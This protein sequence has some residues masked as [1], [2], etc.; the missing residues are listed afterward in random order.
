[1]SYAL[2]RYT[3]NGSNTDFTISFSYRDKADITVKVDGVT[4]QELTHYTFLSAGQ[5]Q[6]NVAPADGAAIVIRRSTSQNSR[7]VDYAAGAV[8]KESDLDTDSTQGFFMAQEA[9]DTANDSIIK[10]DTNQYDAE[11]L[12][13]INV[14]EPTASSD[15]A[16]KSYVQALAN[17]YN[18]RYY[19]QSATAPTD[20]APSEGDLWWD[21]VNNMMKVHNGTGWQDATSRIALTSNRVV[22]TV[23]TNSGSYA[24]STTTFPA[25]Y[26]SGFVDVFLNGSK[27]IHGTDF[28]ATNGT[29]VVLSTAASSGDKVD[30]VATGAAVLTDTNFL[31]LSGGTLTGDLKLGTNNKIKVGDNDELQIY[32]NGSTCFIQE[33]G[34]G[35]LG[36]AGQDLILANADASQYFLS[37]QDSGPVNLYHSGSKKLNTTN[38]GISVT[39][40]ITATGYNSSNWDTAYGWGDHSQ[41]GY[42]TSYT[43]SDPQFFAHAAS[44]VTNTKISNWDTAY[45]NH[46][47]A[48]NYTSGNN[49]LTLT[50]QD[51]GTLTTT[52]NAGGSSQWTTSGSDIY[53]NSGNVGIGTTTPLN[54]LDI[55]GSGGVTSGFAIRSTNEIVKGYFGNDNADADFL[56]TY[57]GS[58]SAELKLK[59]NGNVTLCEAAGKVGINN[60]DPQE[61]LHTSGNIRLG[62]TSP[63]ELYTNSNELQI[64]VDKNN[65]ND[66]SKITFYA[67]NAQKAQINKDGKFS[68]GTTRTDSLFNIGSNS[69]GNEV[70]GTVS[71]NHQS[72]AGVRIAAKDTD[73]STAFAASVID[74]DVSGDQAI[75]GSQVYHRG[76]NIDVDSTATGGTTTN[77]HRLYGVDVNVNATGDSDLIYGI[78]AQGVTASTGAGDDNQNTNVQ[79]GNFTAQNQS[80]GDAIVPNSYGAKFVSFNRST[81]SDSTARNNFGSISES[82]LHADATKKQNY[83]GAYNKVDIRETT[84]AS[85]VGSVHGTYSSIFNNQT[86]N[87]TLDGTQYLYY[88]SYNGT[89]GKVTADNEV[90]YGVYIASDVANY[91]AGNV[92]IGTTSPSTKLDVDGTVTA[93]AFAGDGSNLTGLPASGI[94]LT[95][96]SVSGTEGTASGDGGIGYDNTTGVFTYTPPDLSSYLTSFDITTQTDSKYLRADTSDTTTGSLTVNGLSI[97]GGTTITAIRN[98]NNLASNST[99]SLATQASIKAY[100]DSVAGSGGSGSS[101]WSTNSENT[102]YY[103]S[104]CVAI[105][106][107]T[108]PQDHKTAL[109]TQNS[110]YTSQFLI[111]SYATETVDGTDTARRRFLV[112]TDSTGAGTLNMF[113]AS[114]AQSVALTT[115]SYSSYLALAG[116]LGVG[117]TN[118]A[119]K[120]DVNGTASATNLYV[121]DGTHAAPSITFTNDPDTGISASTDNT[122]DFS[123]GGH[124]RMRLDSSGKVLIGTTYAGIQGAKLRVQ[125]RVEATSAFVANGNG[126][127][128]CQAGYYGGASI[129][130]KSY[131]SSSSSSTA[132]MIDFQSSTGSTQASITL[133]GSTVAYNTTSDERLK[134]NIQDSGDAGSKIDAIQIRQFDWKEGG[135]HQDFGVIAQELKTVAP[136]AV[137]EGYA[138]EDM[139]SVDYSKLVPTLIKEIQSLRNRVAQL[140]NE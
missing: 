56:L 140:E 133:T 13:V 46:I 135:K 126:S 1:M 128:F 21:S 51:G 62:D 102:A 6:F 106:A 70:S 45:N 28:T 96:I 52:I 24:G 108:V 14:A 136:E 87:V 127:T 99:T 66:T 122:L 23:G 71:I 60:S 30:I 92:G 64:G 42:L 69:V 20:P 79:G 32:Y 37:A 81:S 85:N 16:T 53:Y 112:T 138:E 139:W 114:N 97:Q 29:S 101:V 131:Y 68:L 10:N 75:T 44:N 124:D 9:I 88:G 50:Q 72:N 43:E 12:R 100:V 57:V 117:K 83:R 111:D 129:N 5:I 39:G 8:F 121:G 25:T 47:T 63:A 118:P 38:T 91:F 61:S 3:G 116:K 94:A 2:H 27:L 74:M 84:N 86:S 130:I 134:E 125:G 11:N 107:T 137:T 123:T 67:N 103:N 26:D 7:L 82:I 58:N 19:G 119:T 33:V 48:V 55:K 49:T 132:K 78:N 95:D 36:I 105:G 73:S 35:A 77:E 113:D 31:P 104:G 59:H 115:S 76:L 90:P 98:E 89:E 120:L 109:Y 80:S 65:D 40:T 22:Y 17:S 4:K 41:A 54:T 34:A 93:T 18:S 15:A 110:N